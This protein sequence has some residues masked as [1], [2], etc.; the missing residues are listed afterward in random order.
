MD[1]LNY[2]HL[3]YFWN[4][5]REGSV[6]RAGEK[7][8]L[9]QP[10][11]SGQLSVFEAAI[12]AR[13]FRREGRNLTLTET[14]R[15]VFN[16]AD[17]I[18]S[19]GHELQNALKGEV[20]ARGPRLN[21]GVVN[22]L[23]KLIVY[24]LVEPALHLADP[25]Q[26]TCFEDKKDRLLAD[27]ALHAV[28]LVI[29]DGPATTAAG[30]RVYSHLIGESGV[31]VFGAPD[32]AQRYREDFPRSLIGAPMLLQTTN[33]EL[34]RAVEQWCEARRIF[35]QVRAEVEDSALLK[36]FGASGDG[37]FAAPVAV[38]A[39]IVRQYGVEE[40]GVLDGVVERYYALTMRRKVDNPAI[41]RILQSARDW[42]S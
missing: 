12:G 41:T 6:T 7:L 39:H 26:L 33:T 5:A 19:L 42:L 8:R 16:Y 31:A 20:G 4:V 22:A 17:E 10:T 21:V 37:L 24:R 2:Q 32:L 9:A 29:A 14:G 28:D 23:P 15:T 18:F 40:I 35:P 25:V 38:S 13:L 36:T 11:I 27:L 3:F 1:R 30:A 34:R